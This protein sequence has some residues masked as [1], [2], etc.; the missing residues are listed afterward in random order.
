MEPFNQN[1]TKFIFFVNT[2]RHFMQKKIEN[3]EFVQ[4]VNFEFTDS[5]K[6]NGKDYLLI[7]DDSC[8]KICNSKAFLHLATAGRHLGLITI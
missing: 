3:L 2:L 7:L 6:N 5:L 1:L 8:E 4:C